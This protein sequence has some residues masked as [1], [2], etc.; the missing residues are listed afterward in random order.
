M[1]LEYVGYALMAG[2]AL[3]VAA[4]VAAVVQGR[5]E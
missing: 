1:P 4:F 5:D 3:G 2:I